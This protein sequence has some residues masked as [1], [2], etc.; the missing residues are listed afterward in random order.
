MNHIDGDKDNNC[1]S[2]LEWSTN[3]ENQRHA[4]DNGLKVVETGSKAARYK[5][6]VSVYKDGVYLYDLHGNI[7]MKEM[8][9]D[10]R[11]VSAVVTGKRPHH[12]GH[13]FKRKENE[14]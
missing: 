12:K 4:I 2:N 7:E 9:F 10:Y 5:G 14:T 13:V 6:P 8:G 11:L 3:S 1:L